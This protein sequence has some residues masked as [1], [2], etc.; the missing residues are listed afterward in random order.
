MANR[1]AYIDETAKKIM[2]QLQ[3]KYQ[4]P[5]GGDGRKHQRKP[6]NVVLSVEFKI[7]GGRLTLERKAEVTTH[8]IS[9]GG[10]SFIFNENILKG[11]HVKACFDMLPNKPIVHGEVRSSRLL[12]GVQHRIGVAFIDVARAEKP[13]RGAEPDA[14]TGAE[15]ESTPDD[16]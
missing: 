3:Q 10:F 14:A 1:K 9:Q 8:D 11:T 7:S 6:W 15:T 5:D 2:Q 4:L 12:Y 13:E 16:Q